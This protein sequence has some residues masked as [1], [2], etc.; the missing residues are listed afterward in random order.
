MLE[1]NSIDQ[2]HHE[3][4]E[5]TTQSIDT[6]QTNVELVTHVETLGTSLRT[7]NGLTKSQW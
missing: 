7:H 6:F 2:P 1:A 4:F 3:R 5:T